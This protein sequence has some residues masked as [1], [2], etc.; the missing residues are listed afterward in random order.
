MPGDSILKVSWMIVGGSI[1]ALSVLGFLKMSALVSTIAGVLTLA[2]VG[3]AVLSGIDSRW[4]YSKA[5]LTLLGTVAV[6]I[7]LISYGG[8]VLGFS[9]SDLAGNAGL[10]KPVVDAFVPVATGL[11]VGLAINFVG[12]SYRLLVEK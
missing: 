4:E 8:G 1:L 12:G 10:L 5:E 6:M 9:L 2:V 3:L 11:T 7:G